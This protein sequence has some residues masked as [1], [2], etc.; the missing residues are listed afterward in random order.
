MIKLFTNRLI[1]RDYTAH[2]L[3]NNHEL[4]SDN[5]IMY[6]LQ[7]IKTNN[8]EESQENLTEIINDQSLTDRKLFFFLIEDKNTNELIGSIGY[9]VS[10]YTPYGKFVHLGYFIK[11]EYWNKGYT[12]EALKRLLEFAFEEN[13]VYRIHTG[14]FKE[15]VYSERIMEKFGFTKEAEFKEYEF[16]DGKMKDRVEYRLLKHE[17]LE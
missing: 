7:D 5:T 15:N 1:I 17:Y 14:C 11:Q 9:T 16:H 8:I 4:L 3:L 13:D 12:S 2:D 10:N 6:Y